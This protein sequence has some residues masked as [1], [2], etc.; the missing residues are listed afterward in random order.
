MITETEAYDGFYDKASH[1]HRGKTAR[2][3]VMFG[4][5]GHWYVYF[6]YGMHWMLNIV[7]GRKDY[8]AAVLIRAVGGINGPARLTKFL[9]IDKKL[10][11]KPIGRKSG[12]WI[13]EGTGLSDKRKVKNGKKLRGWEIKTAPRVGIRYAGPRWG[14]K[15]WRFILKNR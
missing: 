4:P 15:K 11:N 3:F 2:N 1:A 14:N 9:K 6:T 8:P 13:E 12:F 10:N 5:A 7:V